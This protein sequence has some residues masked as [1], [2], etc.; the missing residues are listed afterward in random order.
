MKCFSS[1]FFLFYPPPLP[2]LL[3]VPMAYRVSSDLP[4]PG[5]E[6]HW[7]RVYL[8]VTSP[9]SEEEMAAGTPFLKVEG[10][11]CAVGVPKK[12]SLDFVQ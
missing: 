3:Q 1:S 10:C 12:R 6:E 7:R 11:L 9:A 2:P 8:D 5:V 4:S